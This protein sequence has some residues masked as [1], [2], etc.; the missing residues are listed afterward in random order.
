MSFQNNVHFNEIEKKIIHKTPLHIAVE[1]GNSQI[2]QSLL[3]CNNVDVNAK[4]I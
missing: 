4:C 3:S 2:V 1:Q